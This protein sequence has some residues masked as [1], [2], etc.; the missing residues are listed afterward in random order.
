MSD[1]SDPFEATSDR[2]YRR[3]TRVFVIV[4]DFDVEVSAIG[5][6]PAAP[7]VIAV[8]ESRARPF[9]PESLASK[10]AARL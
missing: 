3:G 4:A 5:D 2:L 1:P 7:L 6:A 9:Q 10:R 8:W